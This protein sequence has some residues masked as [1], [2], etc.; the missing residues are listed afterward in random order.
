MFTNQELLKNF[1]GV[2]NTPQKK[3]KW[4]M[5]L[6]YL[7]FKNQLEIS[8]TM[9]EKVLGDDFWNEKEKHIV[10]RLLTG[11]EISDWIIE[12]RSFG[13]GEHLDFCV[14]YAPA[15]IQQELKK[16]LVSVNSEKLFLERRIA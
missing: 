3:S 10:E 13:C 15:L 11:D 16:K 1:R 4:Y 2:Q 14:I 8:K 6:N 12:T 5:V 9:L 7:S